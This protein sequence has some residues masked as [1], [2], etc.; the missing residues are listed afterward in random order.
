[1]GHMTEMAPAIYDLFKKNY[2]ESVLEGLIKMTFGLRWRIV[3][4]LLRQGSLKLKAGYNLDSNLDCAS[5]CSK[6]LI[7]T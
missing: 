2:S 6:M 7:V 4:I 1:M 3:W 5:K